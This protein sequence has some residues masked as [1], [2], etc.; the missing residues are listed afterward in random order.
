MKTNILINIFLSRPG[1]IVSKSLLIKEMNLSESYI[2]RLI[3]E[4]NQEGE[5]YGFKIKLIKGKGYFLNISKVKL[6]ENF[7][8]RIDESDVDLYNMEDRIRLIL[9]NILQ[10]KKVFTYEEIAEKLSLSRATIIRDFKKVEEILNQENLE[11]QRKAHYGIRIIGKESD[12]RK[13]FSKYVLGSDFFFEPAQEYYRFVRQFD[14]EGLRTVLKESLIEQNLKMSDVAFENVVN[15]III[16]LYRV[17]NQNIISEDHNTV[18][19]KPVYYEFA[20]KIS[21]W[22]ERH[23]AIQLPI[24][25]INLLAAHVSGKSTVSNLKKNESQEL[26]ERI[27]LILY[28]IDE[29]FLT[30]LTSDKELHESLLLH[31]Y[32]LLNRMYNNFLLNNPIIDDIYKKY[33]NVFLLS[34]RFSELVEEDQ[35]FTIS[36]DEIGYLSLHFAAHFERIKQSKM[37]NFKRIVVVCSTGGGSSQLLKLKLEN[38]FPNAIIFTS[39]SFELERFKNESPDLILT[40]IPLENKIE[41]V[42]V[43]Q[44]TQWL[45]EK[46]IGQIR[47][48]IVFY[49][50]QKK[51]ELKNIFFE[52]LYYKTNTTDY[53]KILQEL[54]KDVIKKGYAPKNFEDEV[55]KRESKFSTIYERGIAGPH[56]L[57]LNAI[58]NSISVAILEKPSE[59]KGREV[60][61][62]FLI[63]LQPGYLF[64]HKEISKLLLFLMENEQALKVLINA[65]SFQHFKL[66]LDRILNN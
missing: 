52:E 66:E 21:R 55:L 27:L 29:E 46:D 49:S 62:V 7:I 36:R 9:F 2:R 5:K 26:M 1:E 65:N 20:R 38:I 44:I 15:H 34:I 41:N 30:E 4:T 47:E 3:R 59:Y 23:Y 28:K 39:S 35:G 50:G 18:K 10:A 32:P 42:P 43:F 58:K 14:S 19:L 61:I 12:Y 48:R 25:E 60:K 16:L 45:S 24:S 51:T 17:Q 40:T 53:K 33:T 57:T 31:M 54:S 6:F 8:E 56:A 13:V 11:L 22:I 64:L 63:N 37:A